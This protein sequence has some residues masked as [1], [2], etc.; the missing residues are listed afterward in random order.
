[1]VGDD[2]A[3][4]ASGPTVA[5][6]TT[7]GDAA[8]VLDRHLAPAEIPAA[9][10]AHVARGVAG[11]ALETVKAGDPLLARAR[12][13]VIGGNRDA[14]AAAAA[15]ARAR[16][17]GTEV[18][19]RALEGDAS[20]TGR[21][22]AER[23]RRSPRDRPIAIIGGGETTVRVR[24]GGRGG[25][26]QQLALAAAL[27]LAGE[28][29]LVLAAGTDGVDGPTDAAGAAVDGG[30]VVRARAGGIDPARALE[31]TDSHR[32]LAAAGD[33]VRTGTTGTNVADVVV[34]LRPAC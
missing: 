3:T 20:A 7:F 19:E 26:C 1:V 32:A 17:Y 34:A 9:V 30:S 24:A 28:P 8:A 2:A 11:A 16:G 29:G 25:R 23:L 10:R 6:P 21:A 18:L 4:I 15:E 31:A 33:L 5:D 22:L 12:A 27:V 13:V 14:V